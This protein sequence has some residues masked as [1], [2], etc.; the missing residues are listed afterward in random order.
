[1]KT[2]LFFLSLIITFSSFAQLTGNYTI[3]GTDSDYATFLDATIA[4]STDG[5]SGPV[6]FNVRS[7]TYIEQII[8]NHYVGTSEINTITFQAETN[9][10]DDVLIYLD[11][12]NPNII[13]L[14]DADYIILKYLSITANGNRKAIEIISKV[15]EISVENC[16]FNL[17]DGSALYRNNS[18]NSVSGDYI[19][20]VIFKNNIINQGLNGIYISNGNLTFTKNIEIS[21]NIFNDIR[22]NPIKVDRSGKEYDINGNLIG[23]AGSTMILNNKIITQNGSMNDFVGIYLFYAVNEAIIANNL[24]YYRN[25]GDA[26]NVTG[27]HE[28]NCG[29]NAGFV[30]QYWY[31]NVVD[32]DAIPSSNRILKGLKIQNGYRQNFVH[33]TFKLNG[34]DHIYGI[35][36][37]HGGGD[38]KIIQNNDFQ[39]LMATPFSYVFVSHDTQDPTNSI[40][41]FDNNNYYHLGDDFAKWLGTELT[42][43]QDYKTT[44]GFDT[45]SVTQETNFLISDDNQVYSCNSLN[46]LGSFVDYVTVDYN[47][48][49]RA[50]DSSTIG[51]ISSSLALQLTNNNG[52]LETSNFINTNA[53]NYTWYLD[54]DEIAT[55]TAN[56]FT[57]LALGDYEV[58]FEPFGSCDLISNTVTVTVLGTNNTLIDNYK[59][60][61]NPVKDVLIINTLEKIEKVVVYSIFGGKVKEIVVT[62]NQIDLSNIDSGIY[63]LKINNTTQKIIKE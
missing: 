17:V 26:A 32:L 34:S 63:F 55:T 7:G 25:S 5:V 29:S 37:T 28:S 13:Q 43:F 52:V 45:N 31:N 56:N 23:R 16:I 3:G 49:T 12:T 20:S 9:N 36:Y 59:V 24:I 44:T 62:N 50:T 1:M 40:A 27:I 15:K 8:L 51:A 58:R 22:Q 53:G 61:P 19:T 54:N 46:G 11:S 21:N 48:A 35:H 10:A 39:I 14:D 47:G 2:K 33:N 42:T 30:R 18:S 60:Y 4:L 41:I 6:I 57:P 38:D